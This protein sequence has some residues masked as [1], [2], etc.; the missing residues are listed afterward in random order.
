MEKKD[1]FFSK[2]D[3]K[4]LKLVGIPTILLLAGIIVINVMGVTYTRYESESG[5]STVANI[6]FF[7]V[8]T[9]T[10]T[11]SIALEGLTPQAAP[12]TYRINV[13]NYDN[14]NNRRANVDL[15]YSI[16]FETT[17]NLPLTYAIYRNEDYSATATNIISNTSYR[18]DG[19]MY[20]QTLETSG[21]RTLLQ[22]SNQTDYY[23]IAVWFPETYKDNPDEYA[24]VIDMI[25]IKVHAE[26]VV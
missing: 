10:Q 2:F 3:K 13:T 26:Q 7:I 24:G 18:Q 11:N 9:S 25:S 16:T 20:Y 23:T 8:D 4:R 22:S 21:T 14:V 6:A 12:F 15:T 19:D 5:L 1:S 17:T